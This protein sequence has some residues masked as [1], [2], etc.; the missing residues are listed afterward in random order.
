MGRHAADR[1][2][3]D[4][5]VQAAR[6]PLH[7]DL[8]VP[9]PGSAAARAA[10]RRAAAA[11]EALVEPHRAALYEYVLRLTDGDQDAAAVVLKETWYRAAQDP[12]RYPQRASAVRPWLVLTARTVL[13]DDDDDRPAPSARMSPGRPPT[14]VR[15]ALDGLAGTHRDILVDLFYRGVS[16]EAAADAH[17]VPVETVKSR[18]YQAMQAL[19][20]VLDQQ[21]SAGPPGHP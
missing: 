15:R 12:S 3:P 6:R 18:L 19:S 7:A 9:V 14:T 13:L 16:L 1:P 11:F 20:I 5:R 2:A 8:F 21:V 4:D 10:E 17:G